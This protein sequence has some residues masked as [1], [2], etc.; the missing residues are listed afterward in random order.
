MPASNPGLSTFPRPQTSLVGRASETTAIHDLLAHPT[1]R[2][3]TL[4][5]PG[6]AGKT[7]LAIH[8]ATT[9]SGF[10][11]GRWFVGLAGISDPAL[12]L[13]RIA[14]DLGVHERGAE[15]IRDQIVAA[16]DSRDALLVIDN[17]EHVLEGA[18]VLSKLLSEIAGIK[19]LVTSRAP[20]NLANEHIVPVGAL[21]LESPGDG[22]VLSEA[23]E[24]FLQRSRAVRP[25][26]VPGPTDLQAIGAI[27]SELSGLPLAIELAAARIRVMAPQAL[28]SRLARPLWL[29]SAGPHDAPIRHQS[30]RD[31]IDWSYRLLAEDQRALLRALG[32]F[33]GSIPLDGIEAVAVASGIC[34]ADET[35]ELA[36]QL[37][38]ASTV[39]RVDSLAA[40]PRFRIYATVREFLL[41]ELVQLGE[42]EAMRD[43]HA[44]WI[45]TLTTYLAPMFEGPEEH[46]A[47]ARMRTDLDNVRSALGWDLE[48][49]N[50]ARAA[51]IVANL[52]YFWSFGGQSSEGRRWVDRIMP[53]LERAGLS[54]EDAYGLQLA[55]GLVAWSEG[56]A[57]LAAERYGH[58][59]QL[60][61]DLGDSARQAGALM[62]LSQA[63]WYAGDYETMRRFAIDVLTF[64]QVTPIASA[65]AHTLLG[66]SE[67]RLERFDVA[68]RELRVALDQHR[69]IRFVRGAIWTLQLLADLALLQG[70][71][72][73]S[74]AAHWESLALALETSNRWG[75]F[76]DLSGL[77]GIAL[78][79]DWTA[80]ALDLM[81]SAE[82]VQNDSAVLPREGSWLSRPDRA[83]LRASL[84]PPDLE[85]IVQTAAARSLPEMV[86]RAMAIALA[87]EAGA[88]P[89]LEET[90][91]ARKPASAN[92]FE[93][94]PREQEV[95]ALLAQGKTDRQI[96]EI[97]CISHGTARTHVAHVLQKLDAR[98]RAVAVRKAL[99]FDLV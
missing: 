32:V 94:S 34:A 58:A 11:D 72:A 75:I 85:R 77:A 86:E 12:I 65:C 7:R 67:M 38:D 1:V 91:A 30:M 14:D 17:F 98:N 82:L 59:L 84:A 64:E 42:L 24:L 63:A 9:A 69:R 49:G 29:L 96:A 23:V 20:L 35:L 55:A 36:G 33:V 87:I 18:A 62:W 22:S 44:A 3:V 25:Q 51:R 19:I 70:D 80:E 27:C 26:Y 46:I 54:M 31:A 83:R 13:P 8:A 5:G 57:T 15:P 97:L 81:A 68:E 52:R 56:D 78:Q 99:E 50:L 76:E 90:A 2:L 37:V 73:A 61:H 95:L 28:L 92:V 93:L 45:E 66:I 74:A 10:V 53:Q 4:T 60:A 89:R 41:A 47:Q 21:G 16:L 40:E 71:R 88:Q 43:R 79:L 39:E 6:G 48:H